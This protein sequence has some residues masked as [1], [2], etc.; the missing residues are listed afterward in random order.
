MTRHVEIH[1]IIDNYLEVKW[2]LSLFDLTV[3][4]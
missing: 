4:D 3:Y 2:G 1:A